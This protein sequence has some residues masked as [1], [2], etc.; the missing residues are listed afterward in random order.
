MEALDWGR[1]RRYSGTCIQFAFPFPLA[2]AGMM[3]A[4]FR[5][6]THRIGLPQIRSRL[7]RMWRPWRQGPRQKL[8]Y[9]YRILS[10]HQGPSQSSA[11]RKIRAVAGHARRRSSSPSKLQISVD[12]VCTER[13]PL[14]STSTA[15]LNGVGEWAWLSSHCAFPL[16]EYFFCDAH[17]QAETHDCDFD[18]KALGRDKIEKN[19]PLVR[20]DK[21]TRI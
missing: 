14:I 5:P 19:N 13:Q 21:V 11:S 3:V 4:S 2:F 18:H 8:L 1:I 16:S 9:K 17:R 12:V 10:L 7:E 15:S 6:R 20:A